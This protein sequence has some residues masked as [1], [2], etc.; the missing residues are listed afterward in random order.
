MEREADSYELFEHLTKGKHRFVIRSQHDRNLEAG[1]KLLDALASAPLVVE[2]EVSL[3][4]LV[5]ALQQRAR[6]I[7]LMK[8]AVPSCL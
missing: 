3:T 1:D 5:G 7:P 2:R 4:V 6:S 8:R